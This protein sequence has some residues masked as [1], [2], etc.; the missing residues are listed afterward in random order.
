MKRAFRLDIAL[1]HYPVV[2][3]K[4][5]V[6]GSAVTNLDLHDIARAG[7][8]FGVGRY[9]VV[10][11]Y[12]Q[13]Q[14][15]AASIAGHWTEGYGGTVN[16]DRANAL[17]IIQIRASLEQVLADINEQD[18]TAPL[19]VATSASPLCKKISFQGVRS[20][21]QAGKSVL[22]LLGTAW[23]LA[24]EVLER[25]DA[26]L[27]PITGPGTYNHLSVRSAASICLDRLCGNW[28]EV[29]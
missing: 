21:L 23:G 24:P 17:S 9:W 7:R 27:P 20:T 19:V 4:Q 18:G 2:N 12:R 16:P 11:P 15:L 6:V 3:K 10:T 22:L 26:A 29:G 5:E 13:Q 1:I 14:E 8:T 25:T 28:E